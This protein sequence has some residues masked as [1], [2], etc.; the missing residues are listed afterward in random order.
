MLIF[1]GHGY[2]I[3]WSDHDYNYKK[4]DSRGPENWGNIKPEW[5]ICGS[6]KLQSPI[7]LLSKGV[8]ELSDPGKLQVKYNLAPAVL[9]K[10]SND[11]KVSH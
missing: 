6:G 1:L 4:G 7:N 8:Q 11:V 2:S 5:R 10:R 9:K 3:L